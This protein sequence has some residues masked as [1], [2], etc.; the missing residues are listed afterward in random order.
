M[1]ARD[2][3]ATRERLIGAARELFA[4]QGFERTTVRQIAGLAGVNAALVSRYFGGKEA[5][6][7]QAVAIDL[8]LPDLTGADPRT[9]GRGLVAHFFRRW[10]GS[11]EDDLLRVLIR[12]AATNPDAAARIR[13]VLTGQVTAMITRLAGPDRAAERACLVATQILG[14][15]YA[16]TVLGLADE[17]LAPGVVIDAVGDTLQRYIA[18]DLPTG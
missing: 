2:A 15:A 14:L 1:S 4:R 9:W 6:F 16:R 17:D 3:D 7:A 5:L 13:E 12:S 10:E 8:A 18:G 11:G